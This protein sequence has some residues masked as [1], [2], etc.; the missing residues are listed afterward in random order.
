VVVLV[1][2]NDPSYTGQLLPVS[3]SSSGVTLLPNSPYEITIEPQ[4]N[5]I[6]IIAEGAEVRFAISTATAAKWREQLL[7]LQHDKQ[8]DICTWIRDSYTGAD[9]EQLKRFLSR[10]RQ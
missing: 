1:I 7:S 3:E 9:Q 4:S 2:T 10:H 5:S 8:F 6:T